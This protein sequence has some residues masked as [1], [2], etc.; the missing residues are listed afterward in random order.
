MCVQKGR[1]STPFWSE[2]GCRLCP[3]WSGIRYGFQENYRGC[4]NPGWGGTPYDGLYG[5]AL[6][7][8]GYLFLA[9]GIWKGRDFNFLME[10]YERVG[11]FVIW[12]CE[13]AQKANRQILWLHKIEKTFYICDWKMTVHLQQLKGKQSSKQGMWKGYHL[14]IG[15]VKKGV[16]SWK[17]V[18]KS[19]R[20]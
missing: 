4:I 14:S 20:E 1:V 11:K 9:P 16:L 2:N 19:K 10:V 8:K 15:G 7:R 3:F 13:R 12:V 17:M 18:Y 6:S 5:E